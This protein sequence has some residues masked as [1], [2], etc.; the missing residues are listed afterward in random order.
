MATASAL[1]G[2][3]RSS[4][5]GLRLGFSTGTAATAA[6]TAALSLVLDGRP[7]ESVP[8]ELPGGQV[9]DIAVHQAQYISGRSAWASVIKD[10]GDDPDVTHRA[11]I[12][13]RVSILESLDQEPEIIIQG[14]VGV[15]RVT[16]PGLPVAVGEPAINPVPRRMIRQALTELWRKQGRPPQALRLEVEISVPRGKEMA[17]HTFNP[18]LGIVGGISIIGTHGLVKPFS[19]E[20]YTGSIDSAL[21][22]AAASGLREVVLTTG[23]KS[24]KLARR[25]R[26]DLPEQAFIQI[27]DF[28][29]HALEQ[30][31]KAKMDDIGLVCFF[32]KAVKQAMGLAYTHA[33]KATLDHGRLAGWF[34]EAGAGPALIDQVRTANTARHVLEILTQAGRRDLV[35]LVG[36][37]MLRSA[38]EFAGPGPDLWAY[39][40]D[41]DGQT[42]FR[43]ERKA[44]A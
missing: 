2:P 19:H 41:F 37:R 15:G 22:V 30:A 26:P 29:A 25:L 20:G 16:R 14:G 27:A 13:A 12:N 4:K 3:K 11:E 21:S 23:G 35:P 6:A 39:I 17:R 9:L 38:R 10:G 1:S 33:H 43:G 36:E 32:G 28:F 8:V 34:T 5:G 24:E 7:P 31:V 42:L 18:R 44:E 40:L